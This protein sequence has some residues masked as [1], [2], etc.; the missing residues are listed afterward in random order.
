MVGAVDAAIKC[1]NVIDA[2][3]IWLEDIRVSLNNSIN[4]FWQ[5][6]K[7]SYPDSI[8]ADGKISDSASQH[9]SF[10]SLLYDI[11]PDDHKDIL[12]DNMIDPP[13][14]MVKVGSPFAMLFM[15]EVFEKL[16]RQDLILKSIYDN[17]MPMIEAGATTVWESFASGTLA[18]N[19]FP[20][21]SHCHAWSS[22]PVYFLSR[23]ILG[24]K[25]TSAGCES[26]EV[27][28]YVIGLD[29]AKGA[30]KTPHGLVEVNWQKN[31][32]DLFVKISKPDNIQINFKP[33]ETH[34][35][36]T[37]KYEIKIK[38]EAANGFS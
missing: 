29:W 38:R 21:R 24:I 11:A 12:L 2:D 25:Q 30:V 5:T 34:K 10:L 6:D 32:K 8:H 35:S 3:V 16:N 26:F 33:N 4:K 15:Y 17:Y 37:V 7:G 18:H 22:S 20:T 27:S 1:G 9:T 13:A 19:G 23:I 14:E 28:P 36:L 31:K